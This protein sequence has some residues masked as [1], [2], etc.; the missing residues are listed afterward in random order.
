M[1]Q[2]L[3]SLLEARSPYVAQMC[4]LL[5]IS[6]ASVRRDLALAFYRAGE[7]DEA[8]QMI[9]MLPPGTALELT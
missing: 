2:F 3:V 4:T 6:V 8:A 7:D 1:F 5:G 9:N